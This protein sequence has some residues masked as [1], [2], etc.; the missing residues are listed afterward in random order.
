MILAHAEEFD[1][2]GKGDAP[3]R[4]QDS[5]G[6]GSGLL[7]L[8]RSSVLLGEAEGK[9]TTAAM[10]GLASASCRICP[11]PRYVRCVARPDGGAALQAWPT[12]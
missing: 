2:A 8:I 9:A 7:T 6:V 10:A 12:W 4:R 11:P 1:E 3:H 5:R